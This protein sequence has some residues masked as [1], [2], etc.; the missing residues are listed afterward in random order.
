MGCLEWREK[1]KRRLELEALHGCLTLLEEELLLLQVHCRC[2]SRVLILCVEVAL[3]QVKGLL[4][5][6]LIF[7]ALQELQFIQT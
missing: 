2:Q 7:M 1:E 6:L 3:D 5:D 4:I